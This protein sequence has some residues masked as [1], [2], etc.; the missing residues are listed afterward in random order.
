MILSSAWLGMGLLL[1]PILKLHFSTSLVQ[2]V[3]FKL[4]VVSNFLLLHKIPS[5]SWSSTTDEEIIKLTHITIDGVNCLQNPVHVA[6]VRHRDRHSTQPIDTAPNE[7]HDLSACPCLV[8][9][10]QDIESSMI[11]AYRKAN[12]DQSDKV[13]WHHYEMMY[14]SYLTPFRFAKSLR[15]MEIGVEWGRSLHLWER[16]FPQI[17]KVYGMDWDLNENKK[18]RRDDGKYSVFFADQSNRTMLDTIVKEVGRESLDIII[19]DG[20]HVPWHQIFTFEVLF[21]Q[22]LAPGGVYVIEDIETSYYDAADAKLYQI[23][24]RDAGVG[25]AKGSA[26]EK[27]KQI[28]DVVNRRYLLDRTFSVFGGFVEEDRSVDHKISSVAFARNSII[29][30]K[31]MPKDGWSFETLRNGQCKWQN[32]YNPDRSAVRDYIRKAK[33][34]LTR[35]N[36]VPR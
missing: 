34:P 4:K 8:E 9:K 35:S 15:L 11:D 3:D 16:I 33:L 1:I 13:L 22:L 31:G 27:F 7:A 12:V 28:I 29:I 14:G 17:S 30:R 10:G 6:T 36:P 25:N 23:P 32:N 26:V 19:D 5:K 2:D 18:W 20:S 21:D 24:V